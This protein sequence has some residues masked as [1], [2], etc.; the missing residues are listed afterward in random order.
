MLWLS[1]E[2]SDPASPVLLD[3]QRATGDWPQARHPKQQFQRE[4]MALLA[5]LVARTGA[6]IVLS[7]AWRLDKEARQHVGPRALT[8]EVS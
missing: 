7:T 1:F 8:A 3:V 6:A 5:E 2:A 4:K